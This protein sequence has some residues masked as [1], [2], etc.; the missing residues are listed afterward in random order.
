MSKIIAYIR[1]RKANTA[2]TDFHTIKASPD[3]KIFICCFK[4]LESIPGKIF[5]IGRVGY[6]YWL[7]GQQAAFLNIGSDLNH[8]ESKT[9]SKHQQ[10][11]L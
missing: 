9:E 1:F 11:H 2:H 5:S 3:A 6:Q 8:S 10:T 7:S 4:I